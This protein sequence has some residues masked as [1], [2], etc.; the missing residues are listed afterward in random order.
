VVG[1]DK[2]PPKASEKRGLS[3]FLFVGDVEAGAVGGDA[4][5]YV[6]FGHAEVG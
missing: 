4:G 6:V 5:F 3:P 1:R 2:L